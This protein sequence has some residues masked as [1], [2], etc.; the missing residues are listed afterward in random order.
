VLG[1][2]G[3]VQ[4]TLLYLLEQLNVHGFGQTARASDSR[5]LLS[6][7]VNIAGLYAHYRIAFDAENPDLKLAIS[8]MVGHA[9][10]CSWNYLF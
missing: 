2:L 10:L 8:T 5:I 7:A 9:W 3:N 6:F 1:I 4:V